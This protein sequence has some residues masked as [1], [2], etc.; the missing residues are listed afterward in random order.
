VHKYEKVKVWVIPSRRVGKRALTP[1]ERRVLGGLVQRPTLNDRELSEALGIKGST[2]TASRR[3]LRRAEVFV[4]RRVPMMHRLGWEL[5]FAGY[6]TLPLERGADAG[7]RMRQAIEGRFPTIFHVLQAPDHFVFLGSAPDYTTLVREFDEFRAALDRVGLLRE[8]SVHLT[9]VPVALS[10]LGNVFDFG[11]LIADGLG[12]PKPHS[13][14]TAVD[15]A[16]PIDLSRKETEV[17][18]G[19]VRHPEMSDKAVAGKIHASRQAVSKMRR[20]FQAE[21]LLRTVRIPNLH[22]LGFELFGSVFTR[23]APGATIS[24]RR[25]VIEK[26]LAEAPVYFHATTNSESVLLG[27][28]RSYDQV[29]G[30]RTLFTGYAQAKGFPIGEPTI[31]MGPANAIEILRNCDFSGAVQMLPEPGSRR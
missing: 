5:L 31:L 26:I 24:A 6:G 7:S 14:A 25:A 30:L 4:T 11:R 1:N 22:A 15:S 10:I 20:E 2:V 29:S 18:K 12:I 3:R 17:L 13:P 8:A 28:L 19:L 21:G 23:Y 16:A 27:A 9:V